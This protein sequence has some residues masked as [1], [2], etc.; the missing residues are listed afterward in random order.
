MEVNS[1]LNERDSGE[2]FMR[3]SLFCIHILE[4]ATIDLIFMLKRSLLDH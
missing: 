4:E 2:Y 1:G 3:A